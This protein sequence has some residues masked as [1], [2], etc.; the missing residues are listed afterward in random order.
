MRR[1]HAQFGLTMI[2]V[3]VVVAIIGVLATATIVTLMGL[4]T[5]VKHKA[6]QDLLM[7]LDLALSEYHEVTGK[8]PDPNNTDD[9]DSEV[10]KDTTVSEQLWLMLEQVGQSAR[11]LERIHAKYTRDREADESTT[12]R[13]VIDPWG[14]EIDY[15]YSEDY[16]VL[17][18]AGP[19]RRFDDPN[20]MSDD[21]TNIEGQS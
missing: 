5:R 3:M 12:Y 4:E 10:Q 14:L 7:T 17:R 11:V 15:E 6:T 13:G 1:N 2:E 9:L 20:N 21:I 16:P 8:Y 19:N 18:S